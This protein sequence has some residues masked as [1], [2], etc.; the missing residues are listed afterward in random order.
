MKY[1]AFSFSI[2]LTEKRMLRVQ[3]V[4]RDSQS[5]LWMSARSLRPVTALAKT[6]LLEN[7]ITCLVRAGLPRNKLKKAYHCVLG[8]SFHK[9]HPST[10]SPQPVSTRSKDL[11]VSQSTSSKAYELRQLGKTS[12]RLAT[13]TK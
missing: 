11:G 7:L 3:E 5:R 2:F 9:K 4:R 1:G 13:G 12:S 6:T 10:R 8:P